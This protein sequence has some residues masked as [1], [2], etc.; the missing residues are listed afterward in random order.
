[1]DDTYES[2]L[3]KVVAQL[4][5]SADISDEKL[6]AVIDRTLIEEG[7]RSRLSLEQ[8]FTYRRTL[9]NALRRLDVLS[10]I[11]EDEGITEI[12]VNGKE[13][14]FIEKGGRLSRYQG[15]FSSEQRIFDIIQQIVAQVNRRVNE[16]SPMV[17]ARLKDG[18]RVNIVLPPVSV[19]G[20]VITIRRFP[21][22]RLM[23]ENL[24][25]G[26]SIS[27]EAAAFLKVLVR[28]GY[29]I[30]VS[31]GTGS[32]KTTFL[33]ALSEF[34]PVEERVITIEDSAELCLPHLEN[35][36]RLEA[37]PPNAEGEYEVTIRDLLR[38]A[39]RMRPS[40]IVIGEIRGSEALEMLNACN[41]G[42][43]GSL[44]T[45]HG[46]S[47]ADMISRIETMVLMGME[48]PIPAIR[49]QIVSA[50]DIIIHLGRLRD[51]SRR[52]LS[53]E[54]VVGMEEGKVKLQPIFTFQE[55]G[56]ANGI[57]QGELVFTGSTLTH[58]G[59]LLAA[60]GRLPPISSKC[61]AEGAI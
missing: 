53:I 23:M 9:F 7:R 39:L 57:V 48:L 1:M 59:K 45:G 10:E 38:N 61:D 34:I 31:G 8:R 43:D 60:G 12:M 46:N 51:K 2:L 25:I 49:A 6:Q 27:A 28:S 14:I 44:S 21:K 52:V 19:E 36:V 18:T 24:V 37:R 40:R 15:S 54:E 50:L 5:M 30:F 42:H 20:P 26:G 3:Q 4:D 29:N 11:M 33:G 32:G 16:A 35:L 22:I 13:H 47:P 58:T 41:T 56:E 17:D 55:K